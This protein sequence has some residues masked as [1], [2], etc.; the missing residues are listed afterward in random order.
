MTKRV[1]L[2]VL[3]LVPVLAL[4]GYAAASGGDNGLVRDVRNATEQYRN[5]ATAEAAG[6]GEFRDAAGL[7]CIEMPGVGG[8]GVHYVNGGLVGD[9]VV[10]PLRPEAVVYA[11]GGGGALKLAALEYIVFQAAWEAEHGAGAAPPSLFGVAFELTPA[12]N[13]Y[14]LPPFYALHAWLFRGNPAGQ[15]TPWN[16]RVTC[17]S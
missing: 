10:D 11:Q 2:I 15:F 16:P 17:P 14:G 4:A 1:V 9:A 5:V 7:A 3:G 13:R 8:M 6:Y 12:G